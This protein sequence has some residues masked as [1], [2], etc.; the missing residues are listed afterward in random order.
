MI[1][2]Q[3]NWFMFSLTFLGYDDKRLRRWFLS[4]VENVILAAI[5]CHLLKVKVHIC[6]QW[7]QPV[8][9]SKCILQRKFCE[10]NILT[11]ALKH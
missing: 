11:L 3:L 6:I 7:S 2:L 5:E 10:E 4:R 8:L 9:N 1:R